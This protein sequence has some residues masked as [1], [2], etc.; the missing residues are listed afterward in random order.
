MSLVNYVSFRAT[1]QITYR[2]LNRCIYLCSGLTT[3]LTPLLRSVDVHLNLDDA[4]NL[5]PSF[6]VGHTSATMPS[7]M[8]NG[9]PANRHSIR[10]LF[11]APRTPYDHYK[12]LEGVPDVEG[13]A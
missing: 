2:F 3:R 9:P 11:E 6:P 13:D 8:N 10:L 12:S 4:Q 1:N 5:P 7:A